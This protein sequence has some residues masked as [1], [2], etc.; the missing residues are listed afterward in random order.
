MYQSWRNVR[1]IRFTNGLNFQVKKGKILFFSQ[2]STASYDHAECVVFTKTYFL[3]FFSIWLLVRILIFLC[4]QFQSGACLEND[5]KSNSGNLKP[6]YDPCQGPRI[7]ILGAAN[8]ELKYI[9]LVFNS[10][11]LRNKID[12]N[13]EFRTTFWIWKTVCK[14]LWW[15]SANFDFECPPRYYNHIVYTLLK[16]IVSFKSIVHWFHVVHESM[17][18]KLD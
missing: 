13:F 8:A 6:K 18:S 9:A 4:S 15:F 17:D 11:C 10:P 3:N 12:P 2:T 7:L 16:F 5:L 14:F 1:S